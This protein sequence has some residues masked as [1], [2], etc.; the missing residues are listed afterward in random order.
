MKLKMSLT[1]LHDIVRTG[2]TAEHNIQIGDY[3]KVSD[4]NDAYIVKIGNDYA[5]CIITP[6]G[7][8]PY[9]DTP[10]IGGNKSFA[11]VGYPDSD[12][13]YAVKTWYETQSDEFKSIVKS[14][15]RNYEMHQL[16]DKVYFNSHDATRHGQFAYRFRT[17]T[18]KA[19]VPTEAEYKEIIL[20]IRDFLEK[21]PRF[22]WTSTPSEHYGTESESGFFTGIYDRPATF[23]GSI[24]LPI[25]IM[26]NIG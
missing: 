16:F 18:E 11:I 24:S 2:K 15:V 13:Q 6:K 4:K 12:L 19:F 14:T 3:F 22:C 23:R 1:E 8:Y 7:K 20:Y 25:V 10:C 26:F 17:I 9:Y 21:I 5:T